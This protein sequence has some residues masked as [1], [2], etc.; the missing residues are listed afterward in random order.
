MLKFLPKLDAKRQKLVVIAVPSATLLFCLALL[1]PAWNR[2][3]QARRQLEKE[4]AGVAELL[5]NLPQPDAKRMY[6]ARNDSHEPT[7]FVREIAALAKRANCE[8]S[9]LSAPSMPEAITETDELVVGPW[10]VA[11]MTVQVSL[12]GS[13]PNIRRFL[14]G[15]VNSR[16]VYSIAGLDLRARWHAEDGTPDTRV[17]AVIRVER[18]VALPVRTSGKT[19]PV[20]TDE[21]IPGLK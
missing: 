10:R 2:Y 1:V 15:L 3:D 9:G 21:N 5:R 20:T 6:L 17:S 19:A 11:P 16:R 13:Y 12:V 8:F 7:T 14:S 18:Y 4:Q